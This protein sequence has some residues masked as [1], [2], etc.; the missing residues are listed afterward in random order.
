MITVLAYYFSHL[1]RTKLKKEGIHYSW[2]TLREELNQ[3]KRVTTKLPMNPRRGFLVKVDQNLSTLSRQIFDAIGYTYNPNA[4][5]EKQEYRREKKVPP[6][7][8]DS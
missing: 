5:R 6:N 2:K 1:L 7:P 8:P 4:T 3:I